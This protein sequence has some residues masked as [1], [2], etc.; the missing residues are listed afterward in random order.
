M[1]EKRT[2]R[3]VKYSVSPDDK[4][5]HIATSEATYTGQEITLRP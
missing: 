3:V 1:Q 4:S 5:V 2:F